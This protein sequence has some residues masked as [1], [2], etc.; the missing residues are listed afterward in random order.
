MKD[1]NDNPNA[2]YSVST[3][4]PG[5]NITW[6]QETA[7][8][9]VRFERRLEMAMESSRFFDLVR[10]GIAEPTLNA[11]FEKEKL[12]RSFLNNARF[13]KNKNEYLPIPQGQMNLSRGN[14]IQNKGY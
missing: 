1:A 8:K 9:A 14:Y 13:E 3:Y 7:R 5:V 10:W 6:N 12:K 11:Y 4:Q 2:N